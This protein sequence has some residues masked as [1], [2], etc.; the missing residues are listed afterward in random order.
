MSPPPAPPGSAPVLWLLED[1]A[2]E[3]A[4][5]RAAFA[6][7]APV[8]LFTDGA[9]L[10][11]AL[12]QRPPPDA[13]V[14][15]WHLPGGVSGIDV[16]Q[17]LRGQPDTEALP[18]LLLTGNRRAEDIALGLES[19]ANDFVSKPFE[20]VELVA[21]VQALLRGAAGRRRA[22]EEE[23][24][25]RQQ[26]EALLAQVEVARA[27]AEASEARLSASEAR[28]RTLFESVD[29][30]FC[31]VEVHFDVAG[32]PVDF[33][34]LEVNPAFERHTGMR[35]VA[36]RTVR[37]LVPDLEPK[38]FDSYGRVALTGEPTRFEDH[39]EALGHWFDVHAFRTGAPHERRVA[40]L[41]KNITERKRAE[42]QLEAERRKLLEIFHLAPVIICIFEGPEHRYTFANPFYTRFVGGRQLV[43][44]SLEEALP[45]VEAQGFGRLLDE[46]MATGV[47]YEGREVRVQ[48][49]HRAPGDVDYVNFVYQPLRGADGRVSGVLACGYPVTELVLARRRA[50]A[51]SAQLEAILQSFPEPLVVAD[52]RGVTRIN[53]AGLDM[54]GVGSLEELGRDLAVVRARSQARHADTGEPV[55]AE[56]DLLAR[57]LAGH[58]GFLDFVMRDASTGRER[59]MRG[60]AAPVVV[61]GEVVGAVSLSADMTER[62]AAERALR[63]RAGFEQYLIGIASHDLRNP[64]QAVLLSVQAL[65]RNEA[66]DARTLRAAARIQSSAERAMRLVRDLLDFTRARLGG[67]IPVEREAL[68][69]HAL[70]RGVVDEVQ[71]AHPERDVR[72]TAEGDGRG[73]LDPDRLSQVVQNLLVN[74]LA[75]SPAD[76]G[77][78]VRTRGAGAELLLEVHNHGAPIA[79]ELLPRLF[80]PMQR[81]AEAAGE[82][83]ARSIGLGLFIVRHLVEAHHG[84]IAVASTAEAGTTFTVRLPRAPPPPR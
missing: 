52:T 65:M 64:L 28:Y 45:G 71:A 42:A 58:T 56:E 57:A 73:T 50:E 15:D 67:G 51:L 8:E 4:A 24:A 66:A 1:S 11:E 47:P 31:I 72:L 27:R 19:G 32:R 37:E 17:H 69:L 83:Q 84:S 16:C 2:L 59:V 10:L 44:K 14:V 78:S 81:A 33:R 35:G 13:L 62:S 39:S 12:S 34:Y 49:P 5:I 74:A 23:R 80:E 61:G 38:W 3:A 54:F 18:I 25:R 36:G 21:R 46:V 30:G 41:F 6:G 79:P 48:H 26:S 40:V 29:E 76:S 7:V 20:A 63:E 75:Y 55:R 77:V 82:P 68:D 70:V 22:V 60:S 53:R 9:T 43:G